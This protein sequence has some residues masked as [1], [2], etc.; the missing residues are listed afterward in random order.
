MAKGAMTPTQKQVIWRV[1]KPAAPAICPGNNRSTK[2]RV[3]CI[4]LC[5]MSRYWQQVP[6]KHLHVHSRVL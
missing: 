4:I 3:L 1:E 5:L 6:Q 2:P